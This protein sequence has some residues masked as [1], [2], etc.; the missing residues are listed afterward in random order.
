MGGVKLFVN[1]HLGWVR[2]PFGTDECLDNTEDHQAEPKVDEHTQIQAVRDMPRR[3]RQ[4]RHEQKINR[5]ARQYGN[6]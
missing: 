5:I 4:M 3:R 6:Q 1:N 2:V